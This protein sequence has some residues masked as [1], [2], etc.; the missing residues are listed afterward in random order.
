MSREQNAGQKMVYKLHCAR[1]VNYIAPAWSTTLRPRGQLHC[2][3]VV[4]H[5]CA[6]V[7]NYISPARIAYLDEISDSWP[8]QTG[9]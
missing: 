8:S 9:R 4:H 7:V 3:S 5:M 6:S 2:A 1:L